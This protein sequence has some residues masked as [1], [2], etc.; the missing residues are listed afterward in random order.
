MRENVVLRIRRRDSPGASPR[1]DEFVLPGEPNRSVLAC[2]AEIAENPV[3]RDGRTVAP[4][5]WEA[6]CLEEICGSC[7]MR[8]DGRPRQACSAMIADLPLRIVLEPLSKFPVVRDL[9][10]DRSRMFEA[11]TSSRIWAEIDG[12]HDRTPAA[13]AIADS[14]TIRSL[15]SCMTCGNCL[16]VCPQVNPR[17]DF[18]GAAVLSQAR[19]YALLPAAERNSGERIDAIRGEGGV[20]GCGNAQNCESACPR[21]I[22]LTTA[23]AELFRTATLRG[24]RTLFRS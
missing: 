14:A 11:L 16:E 1:W 22:P 4:V 17:S 10:V 12:T 13:A 15:A 21:G 9:V 6:S 5:A 23:I 7:S 3:T 2:L 24:I 18:R 8:I 19:L 20:D